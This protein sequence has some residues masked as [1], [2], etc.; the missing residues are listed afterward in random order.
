MAGINDLMKKYGLDNA[1]GPEKKPEPKL[2]EPA[3]A[4]VPIKQAPEPEKPKRVRKQEPGE[5]KRGPIPG[6]FGGKQKPEGTKRDPIPGTFGGR[7]KPEG[8]KQD[9]IPGTFGGRQEPGEAKR[10]P[11]PGTFE[12]GRRQEGPQVPEK[13]QKSPSGLQVRD[14]LPPLWGV[15]LCLILVSVAGLAYIALHWSA[16][17][18]AIA[19]V[20]YA[21][22][23]RVLNIAL[24]LGLGAAALYYLRRRR[25]R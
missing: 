19:N 6:A 20:I 16:I 4:S 12:G 10:G 15:D 25:R 18:L 13:R 3:P 8:T 21:V 5:A 1:S 23:S 22:V 11:I 7:Q 2:E 17:L 9:P 24:L 14:R